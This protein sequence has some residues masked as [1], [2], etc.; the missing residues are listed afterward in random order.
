MG[1]TYQ[2]V[3][4]EVDHIERAIVLAKRVGN[5]ANYMHLETQEFDLDVDN[6]GIRITIPHM[7]VLNEERKTL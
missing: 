7:K 5:D 4:G 3:W 2:F 1:E 6:I